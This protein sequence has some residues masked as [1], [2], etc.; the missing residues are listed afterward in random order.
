MLW[1]PAGNFQMGSPTTEPGRRNDETLHEVTLT[2]GFY[3]NRF[4]VTQGQYQAI[5]GNNPSAGSSDPAP[6]EVQANRPV[7]RVSWYDTIVFCNKLSMLE[8]LG[9]A[10]RINGS[11]DPATWGT[12]PTSNN[13]T[14]NAVEI[15][16]SSNGYR[17]PTEA[18]W[19]YACRAGTWGANYSVY[20]T[21][22][23]LSDNTGWCGGTTS[24]NG[25]SGGKT[26]SVGG[27]PANTW[28]LYDM[29]GNTYDRCWDWYDV[30]YGGTA[31]AAATDPMGGTS[32]TNQRVYRGGSY[33]DLANSPY[34]RSANREHYDGVSLWGTNHNIG[35]RVVRPE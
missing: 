28:G 19:E 33:S 3:M 6:G 13:A 24:S 2:K 8:G 17:L 18:Q 20:N 32:T 25:N 23:T 1:I 11:T 26:H 4:Q 35:C 31:G 29:H 5:M 10:Y 34:L 30:N 22:D 16:A 14:W 9:P 12:V 21:G 15:V 7:E 27:K